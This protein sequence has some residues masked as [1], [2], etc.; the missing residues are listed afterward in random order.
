MYREENIVNVDVSGLTNARIN[1]TL[2][3]V[4]CIEVESSGIQHSKLHRKA[5]D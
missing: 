1:D 2:E 5:G 3:I 4:N